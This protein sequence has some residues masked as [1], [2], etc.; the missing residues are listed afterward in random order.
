MLKEAQ[1]ELI[2][3]DVI[4]PERL[5][6]AQ[7]MIQCVRKSFDRVESGSNDAYLQFNSLILLD[8]LF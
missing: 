6:L 8:Y 5:L 7:L 3:V 1:S 2:E 4:T